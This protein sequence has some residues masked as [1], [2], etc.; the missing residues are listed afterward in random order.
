MSSFQTPSVG[1]IVHFY[2]TDKSAQSNGQGEGPYAAI[3][4]QVGMSSAEGRETM[5]N[6]YIFAYD[7]SRYEGSVTEKSQRR[8]DEDPNRWWEWPPRT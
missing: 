1:R 8:E 4:V 3:I 6:L 7:Q 2:T 5:C